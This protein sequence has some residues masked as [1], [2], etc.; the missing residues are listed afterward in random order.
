MIL[1]AL[2]VR[3]R[4]LDTVKLR[5]SRE[6]RAILDRVAREHGSTRS[7]VLR[8][9]VDSFAAQCLDSSDASRHDAA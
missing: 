4:R 8:H 1:P 2:T 7:A 9:A 6:S 5:I 3:P